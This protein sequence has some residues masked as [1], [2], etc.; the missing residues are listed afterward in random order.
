MSQI[1]GSSHH[2]E[3]TWRDVVDN[4][5]DSPSPTPCASANLTA[6]WLH[7]GELDHLG[8]FTDSS[9]SGW[10][11]E[12]GVEPAPVLVALEGERCG[13]GAYAVEEITYAESPGA[14]EQMVEDRE[15]A[16]CP[17]PHWGMGEVTGSQVYNFRPC[18]NSLRCPDH[19][20][21]KADAVL[22]AAR[23]DWL[24]LDVI[25][26]AAVP[27]DSRL[28]N[29]VRSSRRPSRKAART[30]YVT[31]KDWDGWSE[32][33]VVHLFATADLA[34]PG[35]RKPPTSWEPLLP[36]EAIEHLAEAL[37]LP[38][39]LSVSPKWIEEPGVD[40]PADA[41]D[42][43]AGRPENWIRLPSVAP[44]KRD[45]I[46]EVASALAKAKWGIATSTESF[47]ADVA[48]VGEWAQVIDTATKI[49]ELRRRAAM[50]Q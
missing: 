27:Y 10:C 45:E 42:E 31:R 6:H 25:F 36:E 9:I 8:A 11:V 28:I 32:K 13:D 46:M 7:Q 23:R 50:G 38:G 48:P 3:V 30:W 2:A 39:V 16:C 1:T 18:D 35:T 22:L 5:R 26:Y 49:V 34:G 12:R 20:H 14:W 21:R 41:E 44:H 33:K 29:R 4:P 40:E 37:R 19:A 17:V 15:T 47:P 43:E 24:D